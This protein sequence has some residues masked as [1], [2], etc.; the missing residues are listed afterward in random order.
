MRKL[1]LGARLF[2]RAGRARH[3]PRSKS[4]T[5][6]N[7]FTPAVVTANAGLRDMAADFT[8]KTGIKVDDQ[9]PQHGQDRGRDAAPA[10]RPPMS[11]F[12]PSP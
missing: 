12:L 7:V 3:G 1:L 8:K 4:G 10:R 2:T 11:S 9:E 6:I 5:E